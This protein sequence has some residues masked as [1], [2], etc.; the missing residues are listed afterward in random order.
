MLRFEKKNKFIQKSLIV[1]LFKCFSDNETCD[2]DNQ[3]CVE[4][5]DP[6]DSCSENETCTDDGK[7]VFDCNTCAAFDQVCNGNKDGCVPAGPCSN[8]PD[9]WDC[10]EATAT[11]ID[12]CL[13]EGDI[14]EYKW[15]TRKSFAQAQVGCRV[16][17]LGYFITKRN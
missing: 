8:C 4:E 2:E 9:G 11:C 14:F 13:T 16:D 7:C 10:D 3:Q 6:C 1:Q 15:S 17:D 5:V 12:P